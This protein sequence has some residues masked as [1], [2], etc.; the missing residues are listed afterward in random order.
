MKEY[1]ETGEEFSSLK[2]ALQDTYLSFV[3]EKCVQEGITIT[4]ESQEWV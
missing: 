2:D 3:T 1:L 4:T